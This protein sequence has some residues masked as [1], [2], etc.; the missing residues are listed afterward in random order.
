MKSLVSILICVT[1]LGL[2][3]PI[4]ANRAGDSDTTLPE[5]PIQENLP[6][7][8]QL[9]TYVVENVAMG[10]PAEALRLIDSEIKYIN[11][12]REVFD[13]QGNILFDKY[14]LLLNDS[15]ETETQYVDL[16]MQS[17]FPEE[18]PNFSYSRMGSVAHRLRHQRFMMTSMLQEYSDQR[19]TIFD[20]GNYESLKDFRRYLTQETDKR[21]QVD[22]NEPST[23]IEI[24]DELKDL[25]ISRPYKI[26]PGTPL[27][28]SVNAVEQLN[29]K[30][31]WPVL[32][33]LFVDFR[34]ELGAD[35]NPGIE[36]LS[37][38]QAKV[39][40]IQFGTVSDVFSQDQ[41]GN[42]VVVDHED[43]SS[44]YG[45]LKN[46]RV[47]VGQQIGKDQ[48]IGRA[49][50]GRLSEQGMIFFGTFDSEGQLVNPFNYI[51]RN[52]LPY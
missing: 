51:R 52:T 25:T 2:I 29:G 32:G 42:I 14:T 15:K 35:Q 8:N 1:G 11:R 46:V 7:A 47:S 21:V 23:L 33:T 36:I 49:D 5:Y 22:E 9:E 24:P 27:E 31:G 10:N 43:F 48:E 19:R 50:K 30:L 44:I 17:R 37:A 34:D 41:Y 26:S 6:P 18:F 38:F 28:Q 16:A 3:G 40:S 20:E 45:N 4:L 39:G 12:L 13:E